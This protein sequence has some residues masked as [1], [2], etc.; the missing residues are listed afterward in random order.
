MDVHNVFLHGDLQEEVY[1]RMPPGFTHSDSSKVCRLRKS[2]YG[3]RQAPRCWFTK[4]S[5]ALEKFGFVQSYSDYSLFTYSK[6]GVE[7]RVLVYVDDLV[8]ASNSIDKLTKFKESLGRQFRMKDLGKLKYFL[9]IE[10]ACS[11]EGFLLSQRNYVLDIVADAGLVGARPAD[12][13]VEQNH[14]LTSEKSPL[15]TDPK[16]Y[17]RLVGRLVYLFI[18]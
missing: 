4:L 7:V 14:K 13:S 1:M 11:G 10:V 2:I 6:G 8:I 12:T 15:L 3:L 16:V 18:T 17:R 5:S 9:G